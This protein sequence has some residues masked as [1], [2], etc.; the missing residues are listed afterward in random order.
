MDTNSGESAY[1]LAVTKALVGI[2]NV[3]IWSIKFRKISELEDQSVLDEENEPSQQSGL[4]E[5]DPRITSKL[6]DVFRNTSQPV[7]LTR[8]E[9]HNHIETVLSVGDLDQILE[10]LGISRD[11]LRESLMSGYYPKL[12][13]SNRKLVCLHGQHR[14]EAAVKTLNSQD[15]WWPVKLYCF[16]PN[17]EFI[18]SR[19]EQFQF[20]TVPS[21]GEIYQKIRQ[22]K[23]QKMKDEEEDWWARLRFKSKGRSKE[24]ALERLLKVPELVSVIDEL[25]DKYPAIGQHGL[26]LGNWKDAL[27]LHCDE[28]ISHYL[29]D[30]IIPIWDEITLFNPKVAQ[31]VNIETVETLQCLA[32]AVSSTDR[33]I[34]IREMSNGRLFPAVTDCLLRESIK[35]N[36]LNFNRIIPSLK[37]LHRNLELVKICA[38]IMKKYLLK[39]NAFRF[40]KDRAT[41]QELLNSRRRSAGR[42][43]V[44]YSEGKFQIATTS[45]SEL[46]QMLLFLQALLISWRDFPFLGNDSTRVDS[47]KRI[48]G[49]AVP[50]YQYKYLKSMELLG[51]ATE[52]S[53]AELQINPA[54]TLT[55]DVEQNSCPITWSNRLERRWAR[56]FTSDFLE[57]RRQLFL[58]YLN[59]RQAGEGAEPSALFIAQDWI[60]AFFGR[61]PEIT[62]APIS[63]ATPGLSIEHFEAQV[64]VDQME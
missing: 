36:L 60:Q 59:I 35:R 47:I 31:A 17:S 37:S 64:P 19:R 32:P 34:I 28:L 27:A 26:E 50:I 45:N 23:K 40:K 3:D 1:N 53:T 54:D 22:Y 30:H 4:R 61:I 48:E 13:L 10:V 24:Y 5:L 46:Q 39:E 52:K 43:I 33:G 9:P 7:E 41:L 14:L 51:Y 20:E 42:F 25:F 38:N 44:E 62:L 2:V 56:P 21:D 12:H 15:C 16:D 55:V 58:P 29:K 8:C 63:S 11:T 18:Q 6:A 57:L 49:K